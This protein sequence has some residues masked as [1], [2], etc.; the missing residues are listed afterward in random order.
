MTKNPYPGKYICFEGIDD[1]GKST[2][3]TRFR[4]WLQAYYEKEFCRIFFTK[5]PNTDHSSGRE[6]YELLLGKHPTL[7]IADLHPFEFQSRY[8]RNRI[9]HYRS[10]IIPNLAKEFHVV[11][12]RG[13]ASLCFGVSSPTEFKPLIGIEEQ[14]FLGAEVPFIW[15]DAILVYDVP[16]D[17]AKQRMLAQGKEP[18]AFEKDLEFQMRVRENYL[19][20]AKRYSNCYVI[21]GSGQSEEVFA[22]TKEVLTPILGLAK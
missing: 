20:F 9:W 1:S 8:F 11:A 14:A 17:V 21:D 13:V 6:I 15:P 22:R 18:D 16:A 4:T 3:F 5:E 2:Q 10:R 12:D 19:A 7:N